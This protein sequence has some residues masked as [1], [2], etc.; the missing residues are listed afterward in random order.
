MDWEVDVYTCE[1]VFAHN[2]GESFQFL[3]TCAYQDAGAY[4]ALINPIVMTVQ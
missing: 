4:F 2:F 3:G 1:C